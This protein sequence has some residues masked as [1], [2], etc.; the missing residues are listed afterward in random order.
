MKQYLIAT[1]AMFLFGA[2][3]EAAGPAKVELSFIDQMEGLVA[4]CRITGTSTYDEAFLVGRKN[5]RSGPKYEKALQLASSATQACVDKNKPIGRDH[6]KGEILKRPE[7]KPALA[8]Y[9]GSWL[10]Y[11]DWLSYPHD[12]LEEGVEKTTYESA[13][14]HL[15]AEIEAL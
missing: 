9:Y 5:G 4:D 10:G 7:L 15:I 8:N 1:L 12:G 6:Y 2:T 13:L 14:N 3:A 11:M